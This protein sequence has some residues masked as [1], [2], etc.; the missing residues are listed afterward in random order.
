MDPADQVRLAK[1]DLQPGVPLFEAGAVHTS[2]GMGCR[3]AVGMG[4][5]GRGAETGWDGA[6]DGDGDGAGLGA[7][8][9]T[10]TDGIRKDESRHDDRTGQDRTATAT[11][12]NVDETGQDGMGLD[13]TGRGGGLGC[14]V[15]SSAILLSLGCRKYGP[16]GPATPIV[17]PVA[18]VNAV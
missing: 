17:G 15:V 7:G 11:G 18:T 9:G 2:L 4:W 1:V 10:E 3:N 16:P 13:G 5:V 6:R 14:V 8:M 12:Q